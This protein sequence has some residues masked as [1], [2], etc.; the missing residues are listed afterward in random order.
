MSASSERFPE[1]GRG[2]RVLAATILAALIT[3]LIT[4]FVIL[5]LVPRQRAAQTPAALTRTTAPAPEQNQ[6]IYPAAAPTTSPSAHIPTTPL[7]P[8]LPQGS[9]ITKGGSFTPQ[10][11][12]SYGWICTGDV[13]VRTPQGTVQIKLDSSAQVGS[14]V[15]LMPGSTP[16][17]VAAP[18]G[19]YC[20]PYYPAREDHELATAAMNMKS[21]GC[22]D[23]CTKIRVVKF[24]GNG[25][26]V[27]DYQT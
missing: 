25:N 1:I 22:V 2:K 17:T 20:W 13:S 23:G 16:K 21:S 7:E 19:A 26:I 12:N 6:S 10:P 15:I 5:P 11:S 4:L 24:D 27:A 3:I 14:I 18:F 9:S 8:N